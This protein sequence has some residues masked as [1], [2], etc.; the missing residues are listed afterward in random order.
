M[1]FL[2]K[3]FDPLSVTDE[4]MAVAGSKVEALPR[5]S[6]GVPLFFG[7]PIFSL[8]RGVPP[9]FV[10]TLVERGNTSTRRL[11]ALS[12]SE[13]ARRSSLCRRGEVSPTPSKVASESSSSSPPQSARRRTLAPGR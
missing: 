6:G 9:D 1:S 10:A 7:V 3:K 2:G 5:G 11:P 12:S 13:K 4:R 8:F